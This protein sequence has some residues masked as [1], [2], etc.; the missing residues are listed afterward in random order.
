MNILCFMGSPKRKGNADLLLD[1]AMAGAVS[2]GAEV[3]KIVPAELKLSP[4]L[5]CGGCARPGVCVVHDA[6]RDIAPKIEQADGIIVASPIFFMGLPAQMKMLVDRGQQFWVRKYQLKP[7]QPISPKQNRKGLFIA[8]GG[9]HMKNTFD[10]ITL[11]VKSFFHCIDVKYFDEV[12]LPGI[13]AHGS[14]V[15]HPEVLQQAYE[16]GERLA[17]A[18]Q[19]SQ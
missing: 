11:E 15:D 18:L 13:D 10:A 2:Q 3:E 7:P 6:M 12:L 5:A 9:T 16:A 17:K 8:V 19:G 4:C 1:R 14:V